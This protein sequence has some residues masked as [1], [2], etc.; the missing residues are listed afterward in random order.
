MDIVILTM[1][2]P[3][4]MQL[5]G[6]VPTLLDEG[7]VRQQMDGVRYSIRYALGLF[8]PP[9]TK[10]PDVTWSAKY[11]PDNPCLCFLSIDNKKRG[12]GG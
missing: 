9:A 11:T 7:C 3:Q 2:V 8:Y 1:P 12:K 4:I 10:I 5:G 6:D